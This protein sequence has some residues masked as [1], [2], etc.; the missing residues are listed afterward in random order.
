MNYFLPKEHFLVTSIGQFIIRVYNTPLMG[1]PK[2]ASS[3]LDLPRGSRICSWDTRLCN[4]NK[5][6]LICRAKLW[7]FIAYVVSFVCL[8]ASVG[9][10]VQDAL[11]DKGPSVWTGVA[12][13]LQCV[14]VL[15]RYVCMFHWTFL[16][17]PHLHL[18][19]SGPDVASSLQWA[20]LLDVPLFWRLSGQIC[21]EKTWK[22]G[23]NLCGLRVK[24]FRADLEGW[25]SR[26][27]VLSTSVWFCVNYV[28]TSWRGDW[29]L[30]VW[31]T[32]CFLKWSVASVRYVLILICC[33]LL[34]LA[35]RLEFTISWITS[36]LQQIVIVKPL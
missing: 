35:L 3:K 2:C 15:I 21:S 18:T 16:S 36:C 13:V 17:L 14:F 6:F 5:G 10:L 8:A 25:S 1:V 19:W 7:L 27:D 23:Q 26:E 9:L 20:D 11:T 22:V 4:S 30:T 33:E 32:D 12:G 34:L 29:L 31:I 24:M 28:S